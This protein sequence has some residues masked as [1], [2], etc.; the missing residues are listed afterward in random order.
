[1]TSILSA[2]L[3]RASRLADVEPL[4]ALFLCAAILAVF[5]SALFQTKLAAEP[6]GGVS[7]LWTLCKNLSRL[8]WALLLVVFLVWTI[9]A[10]RSYLRQTTATFQ[11]THGRVT[12]AN[13]NAVQTIWG[14]EQ[15]QFE[16]KLEIYNDEEVTERIESEDLTKPAVLRKK[17][18]RHFVTGNPF[19]AAHHDVT[20][21][22][23][24]RKKGSAFY[25]GY[26]DDCRF[27]W[28]LK[29]PADAPFKCNL[30]FPLPADGAMYDDLSATLNGA[31]VLPQM[32]IKEGTL[33]LARDLQ[34]N[35]AMDFSITFKSRGMSYWY[36][37][38][39]EAREIRDFSLT[40]NLP[41]LPK[42]KLD[43]PE[44]C[45]TPTDIAPTADGAGCVLTYRLDH[46]LSNKGM[47]ISLPRLPQP[48]ATTN[49]I[50]GQVDTAWLLI[51]AM[52]T[53]S[54]SLTG[55][56][57]AAVFA[58]L[59]GTATAFGYGLVGD[60]SDLLFG[61]W[62]TAAL[63]MLPLFLLLAS[64]VKRVVCGEAGKCLAFQLVLF[65]IAYPC[66]AGLDDRREALYMNLCCLVFLA[67]ASRLLIRRL[68]Q[69]SPAE[70][71]TI[72]AEPG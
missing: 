66:L 7:L 59:F 72:A 25:G 69:D 62:G 63:I 11:R 42:A 30:T 16:L 50:L 34:P 48:G 20:L 47:G 45:M 60:F 56:R 36:F 51:F 4:I 1:M 23:N 3:N 61:F 71:K 12:E 18:V 68:E 43:Y 67:F 46:A 6:G 5:L 35:E 9:T 55:V 19:V 41:D 64:L 17:I 54:F 31:D 32:E 37:Q 13:Y 39:R 26:E 40:L 21:K 38:V 15:T 65:G 10:L 33:V 44:G 2:L 28:K 70:A 27:T 29:N 52:L 58:I 24:P 49:A 57:Y 14:S 22:Q 53:L 8:T